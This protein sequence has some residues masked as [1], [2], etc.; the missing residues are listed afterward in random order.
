MT[1]HYLK[2]WWLVYL[3]ICIT[4]SQWV[5]EFKPQQN[6]HQFADDIFKFKCFFLN[7]NVW[8]W[9][10]FHWSVVFL[11]VK[12]TISEHWFRE[13]Y[14]LNQWWPTSTMPYG[15]IGHNELISLTN[16]CFVSIGT[17]FTNIILVAIYIWWKIHFGIIPLNYHLYEFSHDLL[18]KRAWSASLN[19]LSPGDKISNTFCKKN[20]NNVS[21]YQP[22]YQSWKDNF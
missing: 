1:S 7:A 13:W 10:K 16:V 18:V 21:S 9:I 5:N 11:W 2:Q 4:R 20:F 22:Q 8:I 6:G 3:C 15:T 19:A 17:H 14:Y 12:L